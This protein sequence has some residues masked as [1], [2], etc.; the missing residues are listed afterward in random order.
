MY[1]NH[2][3]AASAFPRLGC[4]EALLPLGRSGDVG[5]GWDVSGRL[6]C[7]GVRRRFHCP[8][9]ACPVRVSADVTNE[10][11]VAIGKVLA[12][13]HQPLRTRHPL[14]LPLQPERHF[15]VVINQKTNTHL[16]T[17]VCVAWQNPPIGC[18]SRLAGLRDLCHARR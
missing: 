7:T 12:P 10:V 16:K 4:F 3:S 9:A 17:M 18:A 1:S 6:V 11:L 13:Q 8:L 2:K 5:N 14:E 15:C